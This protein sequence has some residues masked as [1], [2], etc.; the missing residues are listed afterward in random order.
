MTDYEQYIDEN[1]QDIDK[2]ERNIKNNAFQ[3]I[4]QA[5]L[6]VYYLNRPNFLPCRMLGIS[7]LENTIL[8]NWINNKTKLVL[9]RM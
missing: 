4:C 7:Q 3:K 6:S 1:R 2:W 9:S 5:I 8:L